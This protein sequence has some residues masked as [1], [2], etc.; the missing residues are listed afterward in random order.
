ML[1]NVT[2]TTGFT[3]TP[4][5]E[6]GYALSTAI[7]CLLGIAPTEPFLTLKSG[8]GSHD[9]IVRSREALGAGR[10]ATRASPSPVRHSSRWRIRRVVRAPRL[11]GLASVAGRRVAES[12]QRVYRPMVCGRLGRPMRRDQR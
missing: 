2:P 3:G 4:E 5:A 11:A 12:L 8:S 7:A 1:A 10:A 9:L 6:R